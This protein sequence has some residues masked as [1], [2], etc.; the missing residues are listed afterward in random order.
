MSN[1]VWYVADGQ[2]HMPQ[3]FDTKIAAEKYAR[4][5]F[6]DESPSQRYARVYFRMVITM[7]DLEGVTAL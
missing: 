7:E 3:L 1:L 5:L 4:L 6:P 2:E